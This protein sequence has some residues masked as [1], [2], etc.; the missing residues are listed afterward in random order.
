MVIAVVKACHNQKMSFILTECKKVV[1]FV[2]KN[3]Y[4]QNL[5]FP[6]GKSNCLICVEEC[7]GILPKAAHCGGQSSLR[8]KL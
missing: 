3:V 6:A 1:L 4:K 2:I 7:Y 8:L 5:C